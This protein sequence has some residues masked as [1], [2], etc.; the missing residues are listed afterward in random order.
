[1][2]YDLALF[3]AFAV[4]EGIL[5]WPQVGKTLEDFDGHEVFYPFDI[6]PELLYQHL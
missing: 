5:V 6:D 2:Y 3:R 4:D 1:L